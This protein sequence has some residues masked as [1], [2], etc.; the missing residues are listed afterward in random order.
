MIDAL[1]SQ[2]NYLA[3]KKSLD[4]VALRH[5]AIASNLAN[6][7]T[8]GYKRIDVSPAFQAELERATASGDASQLASLQPTLSVDPKA[9]ARGRDGNSVNLENELM[10]LGQNTMA[11]TLETQLITGMLMRLKLAI[12][13]KSS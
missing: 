9:V 1:F 3:A 10:Q 7:E 12:S 8:P 4:V 5:E 2:P 6:L 13:G 11:H